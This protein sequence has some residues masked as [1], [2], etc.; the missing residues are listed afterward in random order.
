MGLWP[1][2]DGD[3]TFHKVQ[4]GARENQIVRGRRRRTRA[5]A[6]DHKKCMLLVYMI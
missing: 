4:F 3:A 5:R 2:L 6:E 1:A